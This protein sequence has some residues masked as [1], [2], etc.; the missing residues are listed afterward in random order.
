MT[1]VVGMA[2]PDIGF[3]V[4]DTLLVPDMNIKG[5]PEGPVNGEFHALK[6][7]ILDGD[8]AAA[9]SGNNADKALGLIGSLHSDLLSDPKIDASERLLNL[10]KRACDEGLDCEF[11]VLRVTGSGKVLTHIT[12][13]GISIRT[14]AYIGDSAEYV[15]MKSLIKP[16]DPTPRQRRV[17]QQDGSFKVETLIESPGEVEFD[18]VSLAIEELTHRRRSESVGAIA[19]CV[20]RVVDA[21]I[22]G[23]LEYLQSV[24]SSIWSWE[25]RSGFS[26]L[27]SNSDIRGIGIYYRSGKTGFLFAVGDTE[28]CRKIDAETLSDFVAKAKG[29]RG[30]NLTGGTWDD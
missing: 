1:L 7:Q 13:Q 27:A 8:T 2:T 6:V 12:K 14:R 25:G 11:L 4:A 23:K 16:R 5:N 30:L 24:E 21:R 28:Y 3:L 15:K 9:F 29:K 22:S 17:Q 18:Q 20:I 19:G 26:V 10:Y